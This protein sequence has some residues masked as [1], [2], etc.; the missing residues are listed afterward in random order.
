MFSL[1]HPAD[2]E[3]IGAH[4]G[5]ALLTWLVCFSC[6][7]NA[8]P[9]YGL[10]VSWQVVE[11]VAVPRVGERDERDHRRVDP[12]SSPHQLRSGGCHGRPRAP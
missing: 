11:D 9:G 6:V 3:R 4:G 1:A 12:L 8:L 10:I 5:A 7:V 2:Q